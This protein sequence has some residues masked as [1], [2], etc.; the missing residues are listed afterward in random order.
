MSSMNEITDIAERDRGGRFVNGGKPGPGRPTGSRNRL[1][2]AFLQDL[3][4]VW[5]KYGVQA[6]EKCAV[7]DAP[8]FCR[9]L[10][11]L[12]PR[13]LNLSISVDAADFAER[14][15]SACEML[16]NEPPPPRPRRP[17]RVVAAKVIDHAG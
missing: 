13:D 14:F 6:L 7:E 5:E 12:L 15:K 9:L 17:L 4:Q 3:H 10:G 2:E 8:A 16:G 11:S 1:S